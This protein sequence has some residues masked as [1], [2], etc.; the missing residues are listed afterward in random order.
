MF[1]YI[2]K[3]YGF[4]NYQIAQLRHA[5][6]V[7]AAEI[8]KAI[9]IGA[10]YI[11]RLPLFL[12]TLLVFWLMRQSTGGLHYKTYPSCLLAS[13]SFFILSI[14]ILPLIP[15]SRLIQL[16]IL[17]ACV[18]ISHRIGPVIS[19]IHIPLTQEA[20]SQAK[21]RLITIIAG[22]MLLLFIMPESPYIT[23]GF[24]IIILNTLQLIV[25]KIR[26]EVKKEHET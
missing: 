8:S 5:F 10:F 20:I 4:S 1:N 2:Q 21:L 17:L 15:T 19:D 3:C 18:L 25:A 11:S 24:W 14:D 6:V 9:I 12:W 7:Y 16:I 13:F 22:Y 23:A 26:K